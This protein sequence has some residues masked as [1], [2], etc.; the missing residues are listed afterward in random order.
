MLVFRLLA[1]KSEHLI[2][3]LL[4]FIDYSSD[5]LDL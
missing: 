5:C 2:S 4:A 3:C 1:D